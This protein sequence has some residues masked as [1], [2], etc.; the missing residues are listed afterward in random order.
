MDINIKRDFSATEYLEKN[1]LLLTMHLKRYF[2][3]IIIYVLGA[4]LF[5]IEEKYHFVFEDSDSKFSF[6]S[7]FVILAA[8]QLFMI[9]RL[10]S[11]FKNLMTINSLRLKGLIKCHITDD[12]VKITNSEA[13]TM[14]KWSSF[15]HYKEFDKY[16]LLLTNPSYHFTDSVMISKYD[17]DAKELETFRQFIRSRLTLKK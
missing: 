15:T 4:I 6:F 7:G 13:E 2:R 5:Y 1:S 16:I 17:L 11:E 14:I 10:K 8:Y 9:I 12:S 3:S